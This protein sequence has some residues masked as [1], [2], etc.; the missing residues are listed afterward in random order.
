MWFLIKTLFQKLKKPHKMLVF[1]FLETNA[2]ST[3]FR[4]ILQG[5]SISPVSTQHQPPEASTATNTN[6][7][8]PLSIQPTRMTTRSQVGVRKPKKNFSLYTSSVSRLP[9]SHQKALGNPNWNPA[10]T[11][12]YDAQIKNKTWSL[13]SRPYGANIINSL[14]LYKLKH[15]ADGVPRRHKAR[16]VANGKFQQAGVDYDETFSSVVKPATIRTVLNLAVSRGWDM[17]Q[18]DVKNAFLH[19][20]ISETIYMHQP[21]GFVD[22]INPHHVCKLNKALYDL[23]QAPRA[24][25]AR[26]ATYLTRLG[27]VTTMSDSSLFVYN[28]GHNIAYLLL[29]VDDIVL[30]GS[31]KALVSGIIDQL[32]TEFPITDMGRLSYFLCI[33]AEYNTSGILLTQKQYATDIIARAGMTA[34]KPVSTPVDVNSKLLADSGDPIINPTEYISLASALQYLTFTRPDITYAVRQVCLHM[35]DPHDKHMSALRSIIRYIQG[36][37]YFGF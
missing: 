3:V 24:W 20:T 19:G 36:T 13:V 37:S 17:R 5:T 10:M 8:Q 2:P 9:T 15:D 14:W 33:K 31:S 7:V 6:L 26:F 4:D 23:K 30:T 22:K 34:C 28:D 32:K 35:H 27:F 16:L 18:L 12:E 21:P 25:N 11:N 29:Y 1:D